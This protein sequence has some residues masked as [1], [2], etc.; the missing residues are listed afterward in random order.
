MASSLQHMVES[1]VKAAVDEERKLEQ[2]LFAPPTE[3]TVVASIDAAKAQQ[4]DAIWLGGI[5][6]PPRKQLP[7]AAAARPPRRSGGGRDKTKIRSRGTAHCPAD[8]RAAVSRARKAAEL[9]DAGVDDQDVLSRRRLRHH[10]QCV[11]RADGPLLAGGL[12]TAPHNY[13]RVP[14]GS[15]AGHCVEI[16]FQAII[17]G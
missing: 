14:H 3:G 5:P 9:I 12:E 8:A 15:H 7:L 17:T 2:L 10:R 1:T 16:K 6:S 11:L 13:E 4:F